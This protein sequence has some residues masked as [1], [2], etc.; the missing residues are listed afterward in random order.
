M[1]SI[2]TSTLSRPQDE[3][4]QEPQPGDLLLFCN[5]RKFNRLITW[6]TKSPY[7]H[8]ALY[9]GDGH[10]VEARPRG[11]VDRD[12]NGPDGDKSF[13]VISSPHGREKGE[14]ALEWAIQQIGAKYDKT[15]VAVIVLERMFKKLHLDYTSHDKFSCGEFV[16]CAFE[17]AGVQ[18]FPDCPAEKVVPADFAQFLSPEVRE[19]REHER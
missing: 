7:Y 16:S 5:A 3:P 18:L 10:V 4:A 19:K 12:L 17:N 2:L 8:V 9:R 15:D 1:T 13:D 14:A 11:V 6:F